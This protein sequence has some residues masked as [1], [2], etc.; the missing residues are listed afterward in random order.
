MAHEF[1]QPNSD[2]TLTAPASATTVKLRSR[3]IR[4]EIV[5]GPTVGTIAELPGLGARIG[6]GKDADLVINDPTVSRHHLTLR[7]EGDAIRVIDNQ[8]R[9]GTQLDGVRILDAFARPDAVLVLGSSSLRL[10]MLDTSIE[11]PLSTNERFGNMVGRSV[12]MRR[13]FGLLER[14]APTDMSVL[15]EG[16]TGTGKE[17]VAE[18]LHLQSRRAEK[19]LVV[20]DCSAV[21]QN[22]IE[23]ELFGHK[24]GA[25]T[26]A[27]QDRAGRFEEADGGTLFLDEIG[28][29]PLE[30]QPKLL[31]ALERREVRRIG[32]D[33][34]RHVDVRIIAATNRSLSIEVEKGRFRED[35]YHRLAEVVVQVPALRFRPEDIP[36]LARHLEKKLRET[37]PEVPP[38]PDPIIQEWRG[39]SFPGNVRELR[40]RVRLALL[41]GPE[42]QTFHDND[43][44][45]KASSDLEV[46]LD[47][48]LFESF[49]RLKETYE[50]AYLQKA[51]EKTGGNVT[52]TAELAGVGR[53]YVQRAMERYGLRE[54]R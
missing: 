30:L 45:A 23:S 33:K 32:D 21:S 7:I 11:V 38:L 12:P 41:L 54:D 3:K 28:E 27:R 17:L 10:R 24:K 39:Q 48:P 4:V 37:H 40:N 29:L 34:V 46:R 44:P 9:N 15:V 1:S 26:D 36:V 51:L 42:R 43:E 5:Q 22:L 49:E 19:P 18:G 8:S 31:R 25:F 14:I 50:K 52:H 20:F 6:S 16:E 35:L 13:L 53:R 47:E 2:N